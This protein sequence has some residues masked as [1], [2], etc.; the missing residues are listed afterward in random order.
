MLLPCVLSC[1]AQ[2]FG[3]RAN[4]IL[5]GLG[6][7]HS[8]P[9]P[10]L[11]NYEVAASSLTTTSASQPYTPE[12][13]LRMF[14]SNYKVKESVVFIKMETYPPLLQPSL[15]AHVMVAQRFLLSPKDMHRPLCMISILQ[16][17]P[18]MQDREK[19][20]FLFFKFIFRSWYYK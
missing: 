13:H 15:V 2:V 18:F 7:W 9:K 19:Y 4:V 3:W 17:C 14:N 16:S 20:W 5:K 10:G 1:A 8:A 6:R 11:A 12:T